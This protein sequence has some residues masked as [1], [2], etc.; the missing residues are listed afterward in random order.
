MP[1]HDWT[2]RGGWDGMHHLWITEL[3]RW[4]KPRLPEGYRAYIGTAPLLAVG[5]SRERPDVAVREWHSAPQAQSEQPDGSAAPEATDFEPDIEVAVAAIDPGTALFVESHGRLVAAVE[6][7]SPRNKDRPVARSA[8]LSRYLGYLLEGAHLLL[9]DVHRRPLDFS[10]ADGI[11]AELQI[12]QPV[13]PPP[14]AIGYRVGEAAAEGGHL[15]AI[16]RR[17]LT[18][19]EPLPA[20]PLP[21]TVETGVSV[22]LEQT[23]LRAAAD[24]Y[25]E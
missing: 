8:Y 14:F 2:E 3:L 6:L 17:P 25:L 23:Y 19:G 10:F 24:A 16:W 20:I 21:L 4:V 11:A 1:L 13:C 18:V 15:L 7:V 22:D 5:A 9:V 12:E